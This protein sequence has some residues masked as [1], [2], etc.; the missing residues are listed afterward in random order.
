MNLSTIPQKSKRKP[1]PYGFTLTELMVVIAI[2]GI[3]AAIAIPN[4]QSLIQ[5]NRIQ[6]ASSEFQSG[7]AMAR[8]EAIK[9]GG[10]ARVIMR[11]NKDA[12]NVTTWQAGFTVFY[13]LNSVGP[14]ATVNANEQLLVTSALNP[15]ITATNTSTATFIAYNGSGRPVLTSGAFAGDSF[16]FAPATGAIDSTIRCV[17]VSATGRTRSAR[18]TKA[19]FAA[20]TPT[21]NQCPG[22]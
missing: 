13:D 9:R 19:E 20:T 8:A 15:S 14:T 4:F 21:A 18:Y 7:L 17:V 12:A 10:D 11:A 22:I 16:A 3:L 1:R 5:S 2:V 6:A